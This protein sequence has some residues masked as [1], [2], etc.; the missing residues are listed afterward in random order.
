M[1]DTELI[2]KRS[3]AEAPKLLV[4]DDDVVQR[5][6]I[7]RIGRQAGFD[8]VGAATLAEAERLVREEKFDCV[9]LDLG[10][11]ADNGATLLGKLAEGFE[12]IPIVV[13]SGAEQKVMQS[14]AESAKTLGF[15]SHFMGKPLDLAELRAI[16][17]AKC[18]DVPIQRSLNQLASQHVRG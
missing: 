10:L 13:I 11:G 16:L 8:A 12:R 17:S 5:M 18:R 6:V 15:D 7:C 2:G 3:E 1:A 14:I 9:T 4:V